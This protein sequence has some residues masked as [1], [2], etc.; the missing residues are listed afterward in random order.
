MPDE[1]T[2]GFN[3]DDAQ[4]LVQSI[5]N[6]E[7]WFPE[8]KPRGSGGGGGGGS[9]SSCPCTCISTGDIVVDDVITS[10]RWTVVFSAAQ[11]FTQ[12]NGS[13]TLPAGTYTV[14]WDSGSSTWVLDIGGDL[15]AAY[16]SGADATADSTLDGT[17]T[18]TRV[19]GSPPEVELCI[20]A[21]I[22][23]E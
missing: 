19:S 13:V 17:I 21:E 10:S 5:S 12:T 1:R 23:E 9:S 14:V 15:T 2:Y 7:D 20:T 3:K 8:I 4:S 18:M 11:V 22:P 16:T 6:G